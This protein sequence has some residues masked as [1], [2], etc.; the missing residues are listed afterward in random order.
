VDVRAAL[1]F[2]FGSHPILCFLEYPVQFQFSVPL[3]AWPVPV[4]FQFSV[5]LIQQLTSTF[6]TPFSS[7]AVIPVF[8]W[9]RSDIVSSAVCSRFVSPLD[10]YDIYSSSYVSDRSL[11]SGL[12]VIFHV[13]WYEHGYARLV[14]LLRY[15]LIQ[16]LRTI[17]ISML[18]S[19]TSMGMP[20]SSI[21]SD[22]PSSIIEVMY[23][24]VL[25]GGSRSVSRTSAG[26]FS[27]PSP[28]T[29]HKMTHDVHRPYDEL[30]PSHIRG[31]SVNTQ[32][33]LTTSST[34]FHGSFV[35][36]PTIFPWKSH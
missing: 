31:Q 17:Y 27:Y 7:T 5:T 23:F 12:T 33:W 8:Q 3:W 36:L 16:Y 18:Y 26:S 13:S 2:V 22:D 10:T 28:H 29:N 34:P 24:S 9:F 25:A 19:D 4:Q 32:K 15:F 6:G 1:A 35:H 14:Y 30:L 21:L 20:A 11:F